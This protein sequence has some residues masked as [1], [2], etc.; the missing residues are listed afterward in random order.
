MSS[1]SSPLSS[2]TTDEI[3]RQARDIA[4]AV[5]DAYW[6]ENSVPIDPIKIGYRVGVE[7]FSA[8][9]G[10][11][12]FGMLVKPAGAERP[13]IFLDSDQPANRFRFTAA[14]ELGHYVERS[15]RLEATELAFIDK[16]TDDQRFKREEIYANEFAG[17]LLMPRAVV[18]RLLEQGLSRFQIADRL[19]VSLDAIN[20]RFRILELQ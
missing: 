13:Q 3:R 8:Q 11:D 16:R 9:L 12:V 15:A 20:Y 17:N 10:N 14:H 5:L 1:S 6:P 2:E 18:E 19:G 4:E 7:M